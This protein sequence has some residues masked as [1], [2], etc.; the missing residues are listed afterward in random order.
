MKFIIKTYGCAMNT[1]ESQKMTEKLRDLG[2]FKTDNLE[3]ADLLIIN[4]C[5]VRQAAEDSVY[6]LGKDL[7]KLSIRP[8]VILT[9][10]VTGA[11]KSPRRRYEISYLK[12]KAPFVDYFLTFDEL[13]RELPNIVGLLFVKTFPIP[14]LA[15]LTPLFKRSKISGWRPFPTDATIF[16]ATALYLMPE[17]LKGLDHMKKSVLRLQV[18]LTRE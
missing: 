12:K 16:V 13:V 4:S 18:W 17:D 6:G 8:V 11:A 14:S 7:S 5:S 1:Y 15:R 2:G 10:C 9:G 3:E